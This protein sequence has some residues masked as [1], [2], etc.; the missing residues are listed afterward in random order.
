VRD[1]DALIGVIPNFNGMGRDRAAVARRASELDEDM[2]FADLVV[3][4]K[5]VERIEL[6]RQ[7]G[8]KFD[9]QE[10]EALKA[11]CENLERQIPLR[12]LP[13][14]ASSPY[15]RSYSFLSAKP[16][17]LLLNNPDDD[18]HVPDLT[19]TGER[20]RCAVIRG[21][22]EH[23]LA[24]MS[25]EDAAEFS[26]EYG[27][28]ESA[29][30]RVIRESYELLGLIS[31]F[32]V[33][34]DEVRAWTI[35]RGTEAVDAAGEIHSDIKRGFIRAEVVAYEDLMAAG[36]H[37]EVRKRGLLRLERKAYPVQDGDIMDVAF[38]V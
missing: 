38:N 24:Q 28:A 18:D 29:T 27:L 1:C 7:R 5:R 8:R 15:L 13:D 4:E 9:T 25:G 14:L 36:S 21:R 2:I 33:G 16:L 32:T 3:A 30:K 34:P 23:E 11:C 26:R 12:R 20:E 35:V 17:L 37:Q 6:E 22:L 10:L 31:F 19:P